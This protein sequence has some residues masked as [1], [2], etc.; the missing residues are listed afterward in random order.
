MVAPRREVSEAGLLELCNY[1]GKKNRRILIVLALS[2]PRA[3]R[4]RV[5]HKMRERMEVFPLP[6]AP[7]RR[8]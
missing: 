8:T 6:D 3:S 1:K 4:E 7:M 5:T 2:Q